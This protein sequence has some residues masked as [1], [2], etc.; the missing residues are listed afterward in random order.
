MALLGV[1]DTAQCAM[2]QYEKN[3]DLI[4]KYVDD[5]DFVYISYLLWSISFY[6]SRSIEDIDKVRKA[7]NIRVE[8]LE[9]MTRYRKEK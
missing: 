1:R 2:I 6:S 8:I 3:F 9:Y 5:S 7:L 4:K